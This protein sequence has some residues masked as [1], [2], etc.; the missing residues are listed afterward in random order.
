MLSN[1]DSDKA[2]VPDR[3]HLFILKHGANEIYNSYVYLML[4]TQSLSM[5]S[6]P[7][8]WLTVNI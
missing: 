8:D 7:A 3:V 5:S 2:S 4:Y 1:L 6:L